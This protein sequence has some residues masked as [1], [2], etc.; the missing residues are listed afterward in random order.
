M[1]VRGTW[2]ITIKRTDGSEHRYTEFLGRAP[3][4]HEII[5]TSDTAG[6]LVRARIEGLHHTP[7]KL[8]G[9]GIWEIAATEI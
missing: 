9:L 7:P 4:P 6:Q 1:S 3:Q 8:V 5:E 2:Q